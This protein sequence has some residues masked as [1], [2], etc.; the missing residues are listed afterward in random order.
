MR[1]A[2]ENQSKS[3]FLRQPWA[4]RA[5]LLKKWTA[6]RA[7]HHALA[8]QLH[9]AGRALVT[10]Q[11]SHEDAQVFTLVLEQG[12]HPPSRFARRMKNIA[13]PKGNDY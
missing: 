10:A 1:W 6:R 13:F 8:R 3:K 9:A 7:Q 12:R 4:V 2:L 5:L 11:P